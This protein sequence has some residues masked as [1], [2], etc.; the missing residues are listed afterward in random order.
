MRRRRRKFAAAAGALLLVPAVVA[1]EP[2]AVG[3]AADSVALNDVGRGLVGLTDSDEVSGDGTLI[4]NDRIGADLLK[5]AGNPEDL[6]QEGLDLP[7]GPLGIPGVML[8]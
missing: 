8:Q 5:D 3:I 2:A 4:D 6:K 1:G 7:S